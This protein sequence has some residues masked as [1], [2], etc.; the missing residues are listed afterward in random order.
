MGNTT[1]VFKGIK[2][3]KL[4]AKAMVA[5]FEK[6]LEKEAAIH[7]RELEKTTA[8]WRGD[9]P[10]FD[11]LTEVGGGGVTIITGPVGNTKGVNKWTWLNGG[12]KKRWALMSGNWR[13]KTSPGKFGSGPGRG[14]VVIAGRRAMQRRGIAA[15]PGIEARDW[16]GKLEKQRKKPYMRNMIKAANRAAKRAYS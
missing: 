16:T 9:K 12:T 2:P 4:Q 7:K 5:E 11:S 1:F 13:S 8:T 3:Q 14:R 6:E 15:R 10:G